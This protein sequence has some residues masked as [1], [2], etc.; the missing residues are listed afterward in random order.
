M[1]IEKSSMYC[2]CCGQKGVIIPRKAS[3]QREPGHLKKLYCLNC[4]RETNFVE[5]K[6]ISQHYSK[7]H[8][9]LEYDYGNF[10]EKGERKIPYKQF[11]HK[12]RCDGII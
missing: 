4:Q 10:N 11:I 6:D 7:W 2:T 8:F 1:K 9:D 12:L 5:I 3:Q